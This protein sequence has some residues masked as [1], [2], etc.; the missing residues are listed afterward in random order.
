MG[1]QLRVLLVVLT[2]AT[3]GCGFDLSHFS[4]TPECV[5]RCQT[6]GATR[7]A[8]S[9]CPPFGGGGFYEI[10]VAGD[11]EYPQRWSQIQC[12]G[13]F[14]C[15]GSNTVCRSGYCRCGS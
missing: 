7:C 1:H 4:P 14:P 9:S 2:A 11:G 10:C 12:D 8:D 15:P 6:I 3:P 13:A 5:T